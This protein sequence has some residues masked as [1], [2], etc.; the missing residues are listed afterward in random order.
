MHIVCQLSQLSGFRKGCAYSYLCCGF[1]EVFCLVRVQFESATSNTC[2]MA[3][4]RKAHGNI[5][6]SLQVSGAVAVSS[7]TSVLL[8]TTGADVLFVRLNVSVERALQSA[9]SR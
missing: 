7:V 4:H 9:F 6:D 5:T 2:E 3:W 8:A 1:P